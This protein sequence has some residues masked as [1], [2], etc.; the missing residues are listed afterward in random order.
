MG[1]IDGDVG[2]VLLAV[3]RLEAVP[4][5]GLEGGS[6]RSTTWLNSE[7]IARLRE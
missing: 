7:F 6:S 1:L 4:A 3:G 2:G 5:L